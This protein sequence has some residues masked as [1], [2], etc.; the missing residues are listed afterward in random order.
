MSGNIQIMSMRKNLINPYTAL[1]YIKQENYTIIVC[2]SLFIVMS[3][4]KFCIS[5][6]LILFTN[7]LCM[8]VFVSC[9]FVSCF[10]TCVCDSL[11]TLYK[12][13]TVNIKCTFRTQKS[14]T[15]S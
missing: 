8:I 12:R 5:P 7:D 6:V 15:K 3:V 1:F 4:N 11:N 10:V 2:L 9:Y 14:S 13:S